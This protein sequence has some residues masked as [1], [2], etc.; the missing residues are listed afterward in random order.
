MSDHNGVIFNAYPD[1][2][3]EKLADAVCFLKRKELKGAFDYFYLL[4]SLYNY[5]LDRGFSVIDYKLNDKLATLKDLDDLKEA[6]LKLKLDLIMNHCSADSPE[7]QDVLTNDKESLYWDFFIDWNKFWQDKGKIGEEGYIIPDSAYLD[8]MILRK[9]G[10][11]LITV[12]TKTGERAF[13]W[14]TF[15]QKTIKGKPHGQV[16]LNS[17]SPL[18]WQYYE[19]TLKCLAEYGAEIIRLDACAYIAKQAGKS[20]FLNQPETLKLLKRVRDIAENYKMVVLPEIHADYKSGIYRELAEEGYLSYDFFLPGLMIYTLEFQ[21][22]AILKQ[23]ADELV[24]YKIRT[25][26]MLGCHDGI[27]LLDLNGLLQPEQLAKLSELMVERGGLI[28][29][30]YGQKNLYYQIN[31]TYFSA[32][33]NDVRK[34]LLARAIQLFVPGI[35]QIWYLDLFALPNDYKAVKKAG[36]DG[37]KEI[38]RTN[39][40]RKQLDEL[41]KQAQ[42]CKQTELIAFR[43][44]FQAFV[45]TAEFRMITEGKKLSVVWEDKDYLA[46]LT[47]DLNNC[48]FSVC[49]YQKGKLIHFIE[50]L[51]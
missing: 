23:W 44:Q 46:S 31:S 36:N 5:D 9:P 3:G 10:L 43:N 4:P 32:L 30:L 22:A 2:L 18:V 6:G 28:K 47:A 29:E 17:E 38:N 15:Y 41:T 8:K 7:F 25:V 48:D 24:K 11:P 39:I 40:T 19:K 14:N 45:P 26:N 21:N 37:H 33:G 49:G 20:N 27:P 13:F 16:D 34:L 42:Y 50:Q 12:E 51:K 35:P 1:S